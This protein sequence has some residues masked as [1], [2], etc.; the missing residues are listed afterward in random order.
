MEKK[1][2][3]LPEI[4]KIVSSNLKGSE[5]HRQ[6]ADSMLQ[7]STILVKLTTKECPE[8]LDKANKFAEILNKVMEYEKIIANAEERMAEDLRD[9]AIRYEVVAK[10]SSTIESKKKQLATAESQIIEAKRGIASSK[11]ALGGNTQSL[12]CQGD[13]ANAEKRKVEL[14]KQL[15]ENLE[16]FIQ[17]KE[18]YAQFK[19]NRMRHGFSNLGQQIHSS[20]LAEKELFE[21]L[22]QECQDTQDH[23]DEILSQSASIETTERVQN[24][25]I[26]NQEETP[27]ETEK[28]EDNENE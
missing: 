1:R 23:L 14:K 24:E 10:L 28:H 9:I 18:K 6:M 5:C 8:F 17:M 20:L 4:E 12:K 13:L 22:R 11:R 16:T 19:I 27:E 26:Q 7:F 25:D 2:I 21:Q 15:Q 3:A